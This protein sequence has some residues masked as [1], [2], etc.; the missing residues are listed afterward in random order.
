MNRS[1]NI[2]TI[3]GLTL[4]LIS[5]FGSFLLEGGQFGA[6]ILIPAMIIVFGGTFAAAMIGS[7]RG[8]MNRFFSLIGLVVRPPEYDTNRAIELLVRL[9]MMARKEGLLSLEREV[10]NANIDFLRRMMRLAIDGT[11]P[12][13]LRALAETEI[14]YAADRHHEGAQMFQKMGGYSPTM[15]IIGTV[16]GL[17][18]TLAAAGDDP[19]Q[20]IHHIASAFVAT[21]WGVLMANIVWLPISDKLKLMHAEE[22]RFAE[23]IVEGVAAVQAGEIPTVVR[24]RLDSMLARTQSATT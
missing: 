18:A 11:E 10:E 19:N 16:M 21:L 5:I 6:L 9:S 15:G 4:G 14:H 1:L 17:I 3:G 20:L 13:V 23:L 22:Q 12:H 24:A 7:G 8:S 2:G